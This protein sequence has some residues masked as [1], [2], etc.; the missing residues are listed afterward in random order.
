MTVETSEKRKNFIKTNILQLPHD[1]KN[2]D[3]IKLY[4]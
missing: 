1:T 4:K 3:P 2:I